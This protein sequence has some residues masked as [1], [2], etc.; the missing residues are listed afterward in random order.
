VRGSPT[1]LLGQGRTHFIRVFFNVE[2]TRFRRTKRHCG[3]WHR[4][5]VYYFGM[6][7]C[8]A[9]DVEGRDMK[10]IADETPSFFHLFCWEIRLRR[11]PRSPIQGG[12]ACSF[13]GHRA[14]QQ[15]GVSSL[16]FYIRLPCAVACLAPN[17]RFRCLYQSRAS[18]KEASSKSGHKVSTK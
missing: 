15:H 12:M 14:T 17:L 13:S 7:K 2:F 1:T 9:E 3:I 11:M 8:L 6:A 5:V 16:V 4:T 18:S 10:D